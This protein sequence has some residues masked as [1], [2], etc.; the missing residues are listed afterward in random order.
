MSGQNQS[1]IILREEP[2]VVPVELLRHAD[3]PRLDGESPDHIRTL[4]E[5]GSDLPPIL[6][7]RETM[8]VIDGMHRLRAA[9]LNGQLET[10]TV[11][12]VEASE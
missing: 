4:A 8:R 7:H 3:S 2:V 12:A 6:V 9:I 5:S 10:A 11:E 1:G